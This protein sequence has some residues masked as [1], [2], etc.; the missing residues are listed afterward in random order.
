MTR[1]DEERRTEISEEDERA[2]GMENS[3]PSQSWECTG[4]LPILTSDL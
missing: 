1:G 4:K 3:D 2:S